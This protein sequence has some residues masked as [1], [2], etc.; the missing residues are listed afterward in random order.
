[1]N[2]T[3][4]IFAFVAVLTACFIP[5]NQASAQLYDVE[6]LPSSPPIE[7]SQNGGNF[8]FHGRIINN[9]DTVEVVDQ[10]V[11]VKF[12]LG[13]IYEPIWETS[14][15]IRMQPGDTLTCINLKQHIPGCI[16]FGDYEY[17]CFVGH[18]I[19]YIPPYH[20]D[21]F[22]RIDSSKFFFTVTYQSGL[23]QVDCDSGNFH[24]DGCFDQFETFN[25]ISYEINQNY[26]NPF[27][28]QTEIEY[29]LRSPANVKLDVYDI[30]GRR[31]KTL[32]DGFN[33]E[34]PHRVL[35]D[36]KNANGESV[37]SGIYFYRLSGDDFSVSKR[38]SLIK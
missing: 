20:I 18:V 19:G 6:I 37:A 9:S 36:G 28:A 3:V 27:N 23:D 33:T 35:W 25:F 38:M 2:R 4:I 29:L 14:H 30:L 12:P 31:I 34:G 11:R 15:R 5:L 13:T 17:T 26:P 1:M 21:D 10:W 7:L 16:E 32:V 8:Y 24:L 22:E